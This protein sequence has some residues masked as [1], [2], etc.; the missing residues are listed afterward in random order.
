M[1][2]NFSYVSKEQNVEG[3]KRLAEAIKELMEIKKGINVL[4]GVTN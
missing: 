4:V 3:V 1:R 2:M